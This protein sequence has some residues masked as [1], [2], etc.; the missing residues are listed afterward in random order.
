[1]RGEKGE[2]GGAGAFR[3]CSRQAFAKLRHKTGAVGQPRPPSRAEALR[4]TAKQ[5]E[6]MVQ[7]APRASERLKPPANGEC[8]EWWKADISP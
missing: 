6:G 7:A 8:A 4:G 5:R 3:R 2:R 1:M